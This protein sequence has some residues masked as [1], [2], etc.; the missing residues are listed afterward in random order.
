MNKTFNHFFK[1][2]LR[3]HIAE[4]NDLI[5]QDIGILGG[6]SDPYAVVTVGAQQFRTP[7]IHDDLNP[8]W[9]YWCEAL[10]D[11]KAQTR[12]QFHLFDWDR[13]GKCEKN[14]VSNL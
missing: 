14:L 2:V 10:V 9:D 13:T 7:T 5:K 6:K 11:V 12:V 1:G 4:A 8:V 3:I